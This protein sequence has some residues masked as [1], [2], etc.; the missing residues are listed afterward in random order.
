M[1]LHASTGVPFPPRRSG[2]CHNPGVQAAEQRV[3]AGLSPERVGFFTDAVFAIAMT[4]LVIEIPRPEEDER[5]TVGAG[6]D[7]AEAAR[8]LLQFLNEQTGSFVAYVL[9]FWTLWIVWRQHHTLF[10]QIDRLSPGLV[11]WHLPLL[12]L[13]GFLPYPTTVFGHH[14]DNPAAAALYAL[15][16]GALLICRSGVQS[17]AAKDGLMRAGAGHDGY[18]TERRTSWIISWYFLAT[19]LLCW[20]TPWIVAAWVLGPVLGAVLHRSARRAR[21]R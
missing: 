3:P 4:L 5:F 16:V 11:R 13:I 20:W 12:L 17:K 6:V 21:P 8:N 9:A 19:V 15:A 10:D 14:T 2:C 7:K 18:R 1:M